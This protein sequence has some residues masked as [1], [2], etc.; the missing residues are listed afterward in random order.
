MTAFDR[1]VEEILRWEG[2]YVNHRSD[3]GGETNFGISKRAHPGVDIKNLTR[4]QAI[5]I[6]Q[7]DYWEPMG[8]GAM[9]P[10]LAM[11][12]FDAAVQ[13]GLARAKKLLAKTADKAGEERVRDIQ[14]RRG[15]FYGGLATFPQFGLGWMRRL[16]DIHL[17]AMRMN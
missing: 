17:A 15:V 9:P 4:K 6:Y 13:H 14:A 8:C 11:V 5:E 10:P 2:G 1:C 3:P 12:I 16:L 7:E